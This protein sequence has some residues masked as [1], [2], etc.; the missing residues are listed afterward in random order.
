MTK[1]LDSVLGRRPSGNLYHYT[2][3]AGFLG[4]VT[5]RSLWASKVHY[6]NDATEFVHAVGIAK[7]VIASRAASGSNDRITLLNELRKRLDSI[8]NIHMFVACL[9]EV[10]DLLSQWRGYC[11]AGNGFSIGV[12]SERL[13]PVLSRQGFG[14]AACVYDDSEQHRLLEEIVDDAVETIS[15]SV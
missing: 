10:G 8:S 13:L 1:L 14:I 11:S 3:Q 6:M 15:R 7:S 9:S 4:I 12:S 5:S 2:T